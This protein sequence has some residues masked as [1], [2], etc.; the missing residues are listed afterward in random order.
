MPPRLLPL[1]LPGDAARV[2][3]L[4]DAH[5][6]AR[7]PRLAAAL[8]SGD[9]FG[10][11]AGDAGLVV[12]HTAFRPAYGWTVEDDTAA[13]MSGE[14]AYLEVISVAP[15]HRGH[16]LGTSLLRAAEAQAAARGKRQ[17]LLHVR[18]GNA[19]AIR[20][21]AREGW[22]HVRTVEPA[23]IDTP[24]CLYAKEIG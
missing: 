21:Y 13:L 16:G 17:M 14:N 20:L 4:T 12:V 6:L 2:A 22:T 11:I 15:A 19:G 9:A 7:S 8:R 10:L 3:A 5:D 18:V 23:W 24:M 1:S